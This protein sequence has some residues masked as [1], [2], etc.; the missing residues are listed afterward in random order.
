MES[1]ISFQLNDSLSESSTSQ[2]RDDESAC[3]CK[4]NDKMSDW[5][6]YSKLLW[7]LDSDVIKK[8]SCK[9]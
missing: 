9:V 7:E 2:T 8:R 6:G 3:N 1:Q 5:K 4:L